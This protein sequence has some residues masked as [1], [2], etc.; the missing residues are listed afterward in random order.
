M[1]EHDLDWH[2]FPYNVARAHEHADTES[3]AGT[4]G[5]DERDGDVYIA[6]VEQGSTLG[7]PGNADGVL[8]CYQDPIE[9]WQYKQAHEQY[10][11]N[12]S[13]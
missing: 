5:A 12:E 9:T 11:A 3:E 13:R 1:G 8:H 10:V 6:L 4:D 7:E 2:F